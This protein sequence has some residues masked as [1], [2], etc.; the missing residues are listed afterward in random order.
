VAEINAIDD[1]ATG[2]DEYTREQLDDIANAALRLAEL[3]TS[4]DGWIRKGGALP[5]KWVEGIK[6]TER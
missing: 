5:R 1:G 3:V 6:R 4:L 2:Q